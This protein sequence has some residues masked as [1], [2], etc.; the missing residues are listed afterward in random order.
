MRIEGTHYRTIW[1]DDG[2]IVIIDQRALPFR[3]VLERLTTV[4]EMVRAIREMHL[5]GAPL[6]GVA[7]AYGAYLAALEISQHTAAQDAASRARFDQLLTSVRDARPTAVNLRWAVEHQANA[8]TSEV[9]WREAV[10]MLRAEAA[11]LAD[12]D[13]E[14]S[15]AMGRYGLK[16]IEDL[17]RKKRAP[18]NILTHCNAG[19]LATIDFGTAT[20]PMYMAHA[21][22]IPI[23]VWVDETR[24]RLQGSKLTA[25]ELGQEGVP[26]TVVVDNAGGYLMQEGLVDIC[27]VGTDRTTRCGDVANK[28]GTYLKALAAKANNVPF[29]AAVPSSSID[30]RISTPREIPIELRDEGEVLFTDGL[31]GAG[32]L[33]EV[34]IAAPRSKGSNPA[35]DVTPRELMTGLITERGVCQAS[36][37]GLVGLFPEQRR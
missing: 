27:L 17:Y 19:W 13:V 32:E 9:P 4:A 33:G 15:R 25:F 34:R 1:D 5:R 28:I 20:S 23:H 11:R 26:H 10:S 29:Y 31:N 21:A 36:E 2:T 14:K 22:G 7:G 30:W 3:L 37:A 12:D 35:F 24:P 6:I 16:L 8:L 18:V